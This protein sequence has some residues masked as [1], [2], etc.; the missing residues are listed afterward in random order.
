MMMPMLGCETVM[1]RLWDY[2]DGALTEERMREIREHLDACE[3]CH[4]QADFR[5][6][7]QR[8]VSASSVEAGDVSVLQERIRTALRAAAGR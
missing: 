2:L 4:P 8:A 5:R 3:H 6:A 7:F 1:R